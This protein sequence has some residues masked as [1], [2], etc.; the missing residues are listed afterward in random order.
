[1]ASPVPTLITEGRGAL[2]GTGD[3]TAAG[4][5]T[6]A[7]GL[8]GIGAVVGTEV[9]AEADGSTSTTGAEEPG[10][11]DGTLA[12]GANETPVKLW[13]SLYNGSSSVLRGTVEIV[14]N[15]DRSRENSKTNHRT[16]SIGDSSNCINEPQETLHKRREKARLRLSS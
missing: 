8:A 7:M 5:R 10:V 9:A 1:M 15:A 3:T 2:L 12:G 14:N 13:N 11:I 4:S 16:Q 6:A